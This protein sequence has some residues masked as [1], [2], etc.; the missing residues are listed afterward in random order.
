MALPCWLGSGQ[1]RRREPLGLAA[2]PTI[3]QPTHQT[4]NDLA[5]CLFVV[6][7]LRLQ[8]QIAYGFEA[9]G[10]PKVARRSRRI[11]VSTKGEKFLGSRYGL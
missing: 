11:L 6:C 3:N 5:V 8:F 9:T 2:Q 7:L 10:P 1:I 4:N